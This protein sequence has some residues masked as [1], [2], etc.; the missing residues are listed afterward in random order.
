MKQIIFATGNPTKAKRFSKGLAK[1]GV[2]VLALRDIGIKINVKEDGKN[3]IENALKKVRECYDVTGRISIGMDD[4]LYLENVP[5][6]KQPGLYV[7]RVE[8]KELDDE[9]MIEHYTKLVKKYGKNGKINAKWVYGI[10]VINESGKE[11]TYTWTKEGIY[12]VDKVCKKISTGYPLDSITK[13]TK[14]N[15]YLVEITEEEKLTMKQN[16]QDVVDFIAENI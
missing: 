13:N 14:N 2:E 7:R 12:L 5:E 4:A 15:K 9:E 1:K 16:E 11:S 10:A 6:E 3:V 8:G